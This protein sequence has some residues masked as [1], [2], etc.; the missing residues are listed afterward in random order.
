MSHT[1]FPQTKQP[2]GK[3][4]AKVLANYHI[5]KEMPEKQ[6]AIEAIE[7]LTAIGFLAK[8]KHKSKLTEAGSAALAAYIKSKN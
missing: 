2:L 3:Y 8:G 1:P 4:E 6:Q 7:R 5:T